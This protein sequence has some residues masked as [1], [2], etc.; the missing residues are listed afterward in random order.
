MKRKATDNIL[1]RFPVNVKTF[2]GFQDTEKQS[3]SRVFRGK[4]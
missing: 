4:K 2:L 3:F 1:T